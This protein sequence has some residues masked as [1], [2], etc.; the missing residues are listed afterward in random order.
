MPKSEWKDFVAAVR[1]P[2]PV[3][4]R[5][6][7]RQACVPTN[8]R[9][10]R[11]LQQSSSRACVARDAQWRIRR[12]HPRSA[13]ERFRRSLRTAAQPAQVHLVVRRV[14]RGRR[15]ALSRMNRYPQ[16]MAWQLDCS[17]EGLKETRT[18]DALYE[19]IKH[20]N[21]FGSITRQVARSH[22]ASA[23]SPL[24]AQVPLYCDPSRYTPLSC[25]RT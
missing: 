17:R 1:R 14:R 7:S 4:V 3:C 10:Q 20:A 12:E 6:N 5:I 16:R 23:S 11:S 13:R 24:S 8:H 19:F 22:R 2:L 15:A 9:F 21:D 18:L 25:S